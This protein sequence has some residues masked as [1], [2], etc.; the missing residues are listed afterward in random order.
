MWNAISFT[1]LCIKR[2]A[3]NKKE[4]YTNEQNGNGAV[5]KTQCFA[6]CENLTIVR[7]NTAKNASSTF[8]EDTFLNTPIADKTGYI[9]VP[10]KHLSDFQSA[11]PQYNFRSIQSY[12]VDG[13]IYGEL[14]PNKVATIEVIEE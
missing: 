5:F 11:Y 14:D 13:S 9:Y 2:R 4:I 12:T 1:P 10:S 3:V 7:L 8:E 6:D